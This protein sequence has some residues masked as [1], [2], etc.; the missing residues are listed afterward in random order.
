MKTDVIDALAEADEPPG[1]EALAATLD[2]D[3]EALDEVIGE[4]QVAGVVRY[5]ARPSTGYHLTEEAA[6]VDDHV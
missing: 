2:A 3:E 1:F 6:H 4:L 5:R